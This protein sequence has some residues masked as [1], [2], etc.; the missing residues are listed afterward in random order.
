MQKKLHVISHTH[1]DREWYQTFQGYRKRLV[2]IIDELIEQMEK[3][4][5]FRF[6]HLDGQTIVLEDYLRIK[7]EN[8]VRLRKLIEDG[9]LIIGPWYVMPDGFLVSGESLVRNLLRGMKFVMN[10]MLS[11]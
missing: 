7:P 4:E 6:F 5:K 3:D 11:P 9:R 10:I 2:A 8:E 1:W